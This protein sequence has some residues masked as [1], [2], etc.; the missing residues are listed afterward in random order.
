MRVYLRTQRAGDT[1]LKMCCGLHVVQGG[2]T[3]IGCAS[4]GVLRAPNGTVTDGSGSGQYAHN[5]NCQ[6][7]IAPSGATH[8]TLTFSE[9]ATEECCDVVHVS[10]CN[11][12]SC[13]MQQSLGELRGTYPAPRNFTSMSGIMMVRFTSD[14]SVTAGGFAASWT[15]TVSRTA[16]TVSASSTRRHT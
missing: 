8:V 15:S 1:F 2:L 14:E 9:F 12:L 13:S 7:I 11:D 3:C 4:C 10:Q 6:W 5:S 16:H